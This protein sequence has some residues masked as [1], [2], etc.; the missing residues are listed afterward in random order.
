MP[1]NKYILNSVTLEFEEEKLS[2]KDRLYLVL[3]FLFFVFLTTWTL[4]YGLSEFYSTPKETRLYSELSNIKIDYKLLE[5]KI[6]GLSNSIS[7]LEERDNN[8][9][10]LIF[11]PNPIVPEQNAENML[12]IDLDSL[13]MK[14]RTFQSDAEKK[15]YIRLRDYMGNIQ[16]RL[17]NLSKS[18]DNVLYEAKNKDKMMR[19][20]P[21]ILPIALS[22]LDR[23]SSGFGSRYHPHFHDVRMHKGIDLTAEIGVPIFSTADGIVTRVQFK[24]RGYGKNITINHGY[25]YSTLYGHCSEILVSHGQRVK[26]GEIIGKVGNSGVSTGSHV[27]YEV[28]KN[29]KH[30]NPKFFF[31]N[32]VS[33]DDYYNNMAVDVNPQLY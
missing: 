33:D 27:H 9:Y 28:R 6:D 19:S 20:L 8:I 26:R 21:A 4:F 18:Y 14:E 23:I 17:Y 13:D 24:K 30:L 31:F 3:K 11:N 25:G 12:P 15:V 10:Q 1:K 16:T 5:S 32:E 22:D 7:Q 29:M 2:W